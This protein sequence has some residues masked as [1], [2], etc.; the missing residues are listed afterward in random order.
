MAQAS[1]TADGTLKLKWVLPSSQPAD[2]SPREQAAFHFFRTVLVQSLSGTYDS[3]LWIRHVLPVSVAEP[4]VR[5]AVIALGAL[6]R[7][8]R[9]GAATQQDD[10]FALLEYSKAMKSLHDKIAEPGQMTPALILTTCILFV[11]IEIWQGGRRQAKSHLT[12]GLKIIREVQEDAS[13]SAA[14]SRKSLVPLIEAFELLDIQISLNTNDRVH[15]NRAVGLAHST[16][17]PEDVHFTAV[18]DAI[19]PLNVHMA[20]MRELVHMVELRA[21]TPEGICGNEHRD[22]EYE[23][24]RQLVALSSWEEAMDS[25]FS[26]LKTSREQQAAR[27][28]QL[29]H[30]STKLMVSMCLSNGQELLWDSFTADFQRMLHLSNTL[31]EVAQYPDDSRFPSFSLNMGVLAPLYFLALKCRE[32]LIRHKALDLL[33]TCSH[34]E[35]VW[36]GP[37]LAPSANAIVQ[38]E[39]QNLRVDVASDVPEVN[40]LYQAFFDHSIGNNIVYCKR[41][42]FE[43]DGRWIDYQRQA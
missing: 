10:H 34:Q 28:L 26:R 33:S 39:E 35:G 22:F 30:L 3:D 13:A 43:T 23:Q 38:L 15:L 17:L 41:R 42:C 40:R 8:E 24:A 5:H 25:L 4:V 21:F 32:P 14:S 31:I 12:S 16:R 36:D 37:T 29:H 1:T 11:V 6:G 27:Q 2:T 18:P 9:G 19:C 7:R 20:A